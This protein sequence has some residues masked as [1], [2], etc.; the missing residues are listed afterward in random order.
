MK[1]VAVGQTDVGRE[2]EHNEDA[3]LVD[4]EQGLFL[5]A[6]GMGGHQAGEVA[7]GIA[8]ETVASVLR[9]NSAMPKLQAL[10]TAIRE[11][12]ARVVQGGQQVRARKGMGTTIVAI[13]HDADAVG[14]AHAGD[15][16]CYRLR[17]GLLGRMTR[18]HSLVEEL[19]G[20][21][22]AVHAALASYSN[23]ITRALG[24]AVDT[25]PEIRREPIEPGDVYLLC[26]DGLSGPVD[27]SSIADI[28][29][30]EPNLELACEKLIAKA[31]DRGGPDN[32]SVV[33]VRFEADSPAA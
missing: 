13:V 32:V 33:L 17:G 12:N 5:V 7:S 19:G 2:R 27:D 26:S 3:F 1:L 15:S 24:T 6:D 30:S 16:R 28:L 25:V 8:R 10:D 18:D 22:P 20:D 9:E 29:K 11:A 4:L 23:V 21:D 31:N 14:I